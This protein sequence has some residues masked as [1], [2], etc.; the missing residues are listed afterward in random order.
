MANDDDA[1]NRWEAGQRLAAST[2]LREGRQPDAGFRRCGAQAAARS[3]PGIR[4]RGASL[5]AES[6]P[7][8]AARGGRSRQA[9]RRRATACGASSR[10]RSRKTCWRPTRQLKIK[11]PYSPDAESSGKRALR[12]LCLSYL[13][14]IGH[15]ALAYE[16]YH[17]AG[18]MTDA[19]AALTALA[20]V[21]CPSG[22]RRSKRSTRSG[23]TSRWSSTSGSR[24][25]RPRACPER[26]PA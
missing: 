7:R 10:P 24:C 2:I 23:R 11:A 1:F 17:T 13:V 25:R 21:D 16:Q 6:F 26:S 18:N 19:M 3:R 5:P 15:S 22:C 9:A 8:R 20:N 12:N 4:R 14:E